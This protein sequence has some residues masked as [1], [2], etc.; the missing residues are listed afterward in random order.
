MANITFTSPRL[1]RDLTV[2]AV[3]GDRGT[4]LAVAKANRV[5]LPFDCQDG[6]C[7]SCLVEVKHVD[8]SAKHAISLTE[9]EKEMLRQLGKI[10][11]QEVVDAETSDLP[12]R[13]RLACQCVVRH[14]DIVVSFAGDET[15]PARGPHVT[16]AA[17]LREGG[18]DLGSLEEF[19][20]YAV[21]VE[22]DAAAH[23]DRLGTAME[24]V[25]NAEVALLFKQLAGYSRLHLA[26]AQARVGER[27]V[28]PL[29]PPAYVWP[30]HATPER[31][32]LWAGDASLSR[33]D[34][35]RAALVG[36][37]KG[38]DFYYTV[39][40]TSALREVRELAAEFVKEE[41]EHVQVLEAWILREA[42]LERNRA[43]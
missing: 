30:D 37:K 7:G 5:P 17:V 23:F 14:E 18:F 3:A 35:L 15:L 39:A 43:P 16:P 27:D 24:E 12:P 34:A 38:Y 26:Q 20:A 25:G 19:L 32:A 13:F 40:R 22:A 33:K 11:P 6:Q 1:P 8:P 41:A 29:I 9:K 42:W 31:T 28:T 36:E 2:Y 4:L 21:K 10:T